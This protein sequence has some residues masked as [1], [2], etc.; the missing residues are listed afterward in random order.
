MVY[1]AIL[2]ML[3]DGRARH[4]YDL[5]REYRTRSG[6]PVN[7]GNFYRECG[8]LLAQRLIVPEDRPPDADPRRIPY[9]IT[10]AGCREFDA[11]LLEPR[12]MQ[13]SFDN[14]M[15]FADML[16]AAERLRL[17]DEARE[18]LWGHG[19]SLGTERERVLSRWRRLP[20]PRGYNP[21][22]FLMLR[23]LTQ[24]T[25][26]IEFLQELRRELDRVPPSPLNVSIGASPEMTV[27]VARDS[28]IATPTSRG[29]KT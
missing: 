12:P 29:R 27:P 28:G 5:V 7:A 10:V 4:V 13:P 14:W 22:S 16:S 24:I 11:W 25:A 17:V 20:E 18:T 26:E 21:A 9:R 6:R 3:R 8:K 23:R 15:I 2:G 1:H 19:K